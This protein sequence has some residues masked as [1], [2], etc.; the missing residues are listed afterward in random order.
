LLGIKIGIEKLLI[1]K[2]KV[3]FRKVYKAPAKVI[4]SFQVQSRFYI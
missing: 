1:T 2:L 3:K 4:G